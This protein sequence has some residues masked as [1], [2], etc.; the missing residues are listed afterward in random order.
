MRDMPDHTSDDMARI[1]AALLELIPGVGVPFL[2]LPTPEDVAAKSG[3]HLDDVHAIMANPETV[4]EFL[5][6]PLALDADRALSATTISRNPSMSDQRAILRRGI[7]VARR[8]PYEVRLLLLLLDRMA[9]PS[10]NMLADNI[11]YSGGLRLIGIDHEEEPEMRFRATLAWELISIAVIS[12]R[13]GLED[14][15][16]DEETLES[17]VTACMGIL[18]PPTD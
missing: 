11:L 12:H 8:H 5:M 10:A 6:A 14:A 13:H 1:R 17:L 15:D 9:P 2:V 3:A 4:L 18:H 16:T 7:G